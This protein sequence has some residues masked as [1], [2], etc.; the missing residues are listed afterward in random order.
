M[1]PQSLKPRTVET[2]LTASEDPEADQ[3]MDSNAI[4][5][6]TTSPAINVSSVDCDRNSHAACDTD[7]DMHNPVVPTHAVI[8]TDFI[9]ENSE[10]QK[11]IENS[12]NPKKNSVSVPSVSVPSVSVPSV[13]VPSVSVPSVS[14]PSV[15]VPSV[16]SS[17]TASNP[18]APAVNVTRPIQTYAQATAGDKRTPR[19]TTNTNDPSFQNVLM[20]FERTFKW[21]SHIKIL[22]FKHRDKNARNS[23]RSWKL[24]ISSKITPVLI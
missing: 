22:D 8:S 3:N 10:N 11:K 18:V 13:S 2:F 12:Q 4:S 14:V 15:S 9:N 16:S 23:S 7:I 6:P 20:K 24:K 19:A 17:T 5:T 1:I 21:A